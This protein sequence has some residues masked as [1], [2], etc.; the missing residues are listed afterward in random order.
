MLPPDLVPYR[1][2]AEFT[3]ATVPPGLLRAHSTKDGAWG[4]IHVLAG[5]LAYRVTDPRR[6][7]SETILTAEGEPGV[8]EPT[9]LHEVEP[10][11]PARFYVEFLRPRQ[12]AD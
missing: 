11:G 2:T 4:L 5:R 6:A 8:V 10:L 12:A 3:E 9:V 1:R 7:P